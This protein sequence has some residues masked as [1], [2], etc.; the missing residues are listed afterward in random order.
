MLFRVGV[1]RWYWAR[2]Y[3]LCTFRSYYIITCLYSSGMRVNNNGMFTHIHIYKRIRNTSIPL[4][5]QPNTALNISNYEEQKLYSSSTT[6]NQNVH[7][8]IFGY[9][10]AVISTLPKY[11]CIY[12]LTRAHITHKKI[13]AHGIHALSNCFLSMYLY[14][15]LFLL[16]LKNH[17]LT[18]T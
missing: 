5:I 8:Q 15:K 9:D 14:E 1:P 10:L 11:L 7:L 18:I 13:L 16:L 2:E 3:D 12:A 17:L 6:D 4:N